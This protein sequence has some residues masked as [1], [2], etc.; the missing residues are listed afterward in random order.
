MI[1]AVVAYSLEKTQGKTVRRDSAVCPYK[2]REVET[3]V[4][5]RGQDRTI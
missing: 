2:I 4:S 3:G 1:S 5:N